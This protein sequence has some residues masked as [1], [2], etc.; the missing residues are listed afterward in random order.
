MRLSRPHAWAT[1]SLAVCIKKTQLSNSIH[2]HQLNP[3]NPLPFVCDNWLPT[4]TKSRANT[5][6]MFSIA[7]MLSGE[8]PSSYLVYTTGRGFPPAIEGIPQAMKGI[9][10]VFMLAMLTGSDCNNVRPNTVKYIYL[11][12][13]GVVEQV[14][15]TRRSPDQYFHRPCNIQCIH[16]FPFQLSAHSVYISLVLSQSPPS[17]EEKWSSEPSQIPQASALF[18]NSVTQHTK[19]FQ[20]NL[21]QTCSKKDMDTRVEIKFFTVIREVLCNNFQ[22]RNLICPYHLGNKSKVQE[23]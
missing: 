13:T 14:W 3:Q 1:N 23:I 9:A 11:T 4:L 17:H 19:Q 20:N 16:T 5:E 10:T 22:S 21:H 2:F 7:A 18:C 8:E 12:N 15:R 6:C